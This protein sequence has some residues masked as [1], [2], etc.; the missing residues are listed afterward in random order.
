MTMKLWHS[1]LPVPCELFGILSCLMKMSI[2]LKQYGEGWRRLIVELCLWDVLLDMWIID[3][4]N[5]HTW[6]RSEKPV[7]IEEV[8]V[9]QWGKQHIFSDSYTHYLKQNVT[10]IVWTL[11]NVSMKEKFKLNHSSNCVLIVGHNL[12]HNLHSIFF[13]PFPVQTFSSIVII[14]KVRKL[15]QL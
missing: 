15:G 10:N 6:K 1:Y 11:K 3:V 13:V 2:V 5:G 8:I 4:L 12:R 14:H 9:K 7:I